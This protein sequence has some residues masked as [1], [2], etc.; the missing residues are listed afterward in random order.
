[1]HRLCVA[2]VLAC[3]AGV[4]PSC[5]SHKK[6][7]ADIAVIEHTGGKKLPHDIG[8]ELVAEAMTWIG[9]PY[10]YACQTKGTSTD[11]SGMVMKV[12]ESVG[13]VMLPRNSA[14]QAEYCQDLDRKDVEVGDLVFFATGKDK[15]RISHV[16]IMIDT[17]RF[18]H[19]SSSKG[20]V[21]S[22]IDTPY[23]TRTLRKFGRVPGISATRSKAA[24]KK[25]LSEKKRKRRKRK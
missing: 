24:E 8:G 20:V 23:Y 3:I 22:Q 9:T 25:P 13:G 21:I 16:G 15:N 12:Y 1:M 4:L 7:K 2:M 10:Q 6:P 5:R 19:A 17:K 14:K 18:I 11:C